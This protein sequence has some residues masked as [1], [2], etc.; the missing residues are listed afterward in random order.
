M[1][2]VVVVV[3]GRV[4]DSVLGSGD[5]TLSF[6]R[7]AIWSSFGRETAALAFFRPSSGEKKS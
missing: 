6:Y 2:V 3:R 5:G 1:V 4:E 7:I